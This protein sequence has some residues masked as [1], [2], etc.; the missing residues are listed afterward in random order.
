VREPALIR[1]LR[2]RCRQPLQVLAGSVAGM[3][4]M[5]A[6]VGEGDR[7]FA[8]DVV[9]TIDVAK[10]VLAEPATVVPFPI[11]AG[12]ARAIPRNSF[13]RVRGLPPMAALTEGYSIGPGSWAVPLQALA[14]LKITL[15]L[16]TAGSAAVTVSL[17]AIDGSVLAE[18][19]TTLVVNPPLRNNPPPPSGAPAS[20]FEPRAPQAPQAGRGEREFPA[21]SPSML[22][23]ATADRERAL[24]LL[25]KGEEQ[26][27]Q[28]LV[29]P[30][31]LLFERAADLGLAQAALALGATYDAAELDKPNLRGIGP[32]IKEAKRWYARALELGASEAEIRLRR[33]GA[34]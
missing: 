4:V 5:L 21:P 24:Q 7:A 25:K 18:V 12:P 14:D 10:T 28:G 11:R 9:P 16:A 13:I 3:M 23:P 8:Q 1:G 32:D 26:L 33:L 2:Q 19:R 6:P 15:P 27:A 22:T 29:A 30:A 17:V 31:R 34:N 20:A